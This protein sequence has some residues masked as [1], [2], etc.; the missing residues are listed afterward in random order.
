M[1]PATPALV[2]WAVVMAISFPLQTSV[3]VG[4]DLQLD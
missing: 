4:L 3:M 2:V 1:S